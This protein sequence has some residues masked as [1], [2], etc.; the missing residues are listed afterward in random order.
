MRLTLAAVVSV[1]VFSSSAWAQASGAQA[2]EDGPE[3]SDIIV[4]A[5]GGLHDLDDAVGVDAGDIGRPGRPNLLQALARTVPGLSL[6]DAQNNPWQP[7]LV[8]RGFTISPL[9]GQSQG[10]AVYLDGG[11]FNQPF[12][13]TVQFDLLPEVAIERVDLLDA[14]PI[15]GLNALGGAMVI[16][17][18]TGRSAP[19]FR[20]SGSGG[21]Y[22]EAQGLAEAGWAGDQASAYVAVQERHDGGWRRFSPSTLYNG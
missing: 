3:R 5:P 7:N 12:G 6:Q 2:S 9:Q 22:G 16:A 14:S 17:T 13:D 15:Y 21:R 10:L 8:Y 19:G 11:R 20:L 4:T 1:M 18:K